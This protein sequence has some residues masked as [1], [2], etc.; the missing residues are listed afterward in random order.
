LT[1]LAVDDGVVVTWINRSNGPAKVM[2]VEFE[3]RKSMEFLA[4]GLKGL[5]LG[6]NVTLIESSTKLSESRVDQ[7]SG[8]LTTKYVQDA[9][10]LRSVSL[11]SSIWT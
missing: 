6:A 5:S 2:G 8:G 1:S 7:Y 3:A 10:T 9:A 11:I 4:S